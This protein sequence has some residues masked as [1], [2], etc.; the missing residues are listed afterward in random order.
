MTAENLTSNTDSATAAA[1]FNANATFDSPP[2]PSAKPAS[3]PAKGRL[4]SAAFYRPTA[5][6]EGTAKEHFD[7]VQK[8]PIQRV[9]TQWEFAA[10]QPPVGLLLSR[11]YGT[12]RFSFGRG[13]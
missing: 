11:H 8:G 7:R 4:M 9:A 1:R 5:A 10:I 2:P 6:S 12:G 13:R 3:G